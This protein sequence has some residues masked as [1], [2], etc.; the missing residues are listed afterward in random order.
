VVN[1]EA[2]GSDSAKGKVERAISQLGYRHTLAASTL[3]RTNARTNTVGV[4]LQDVSNSFSAALLRSLE[5]AARERDV[6]ILASSLDEEA[7]RERNLV[8]NLVRRRVDGLVLMP[9]THRQDYLADELR[10]GLPVVF[11]DR[12]PHG[13]DADSVTVD[14]RGGAAAATTHLIQGG[15]RRIA[16]LGDLATI[17]TA[18]ARLEGFRAAHAAADLPVD[19]RLEVTGLRSEEPARDAVSALLALDEPPTALFAARN[20][21][22]IGAVQALRA[23]GRTGDVALVGF[24]DFPLADVLD[25]GLTVVRQNVRRIGAEV[26]GRLFARLDGDE[27]P[28]HHLVIEPVLVPRGSGEISP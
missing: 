12:P 9:A 7:D 2:G 24:D 22:A 10:N 14:N 4:L 20:S 27:S 21:L 15:H 19:P 28:P 11:V 5:D 16:Y 18:A 25:P 23:H 1:A 8:A 6:A 17:E 13:I 26:A 3:R